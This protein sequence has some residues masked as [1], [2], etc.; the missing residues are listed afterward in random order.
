MVIV[1]SADIATEMLT[2]KASIYSDRPQLV[3]FGELVG[4]NRFLSFTPYGSLW[5][6]QRTLLQKTIGTAAS[7]KQFSGIEEAEAHRLLKHI[8]NDPENLVNHI[9]MSVTS[10]HNVLHSLMILRAAGSIILR[11]SYGYETADG[12][13]SLVDLAETVMDGFATTLRPGA[14]LVDL[15][16]IREELLHIPAL[17]LTLIKSSTYHIGF[18][19]SPS[20]ERLTNGDKIFRASWRYHT[21]WSRHLWYG[22]EHWVV[23]FTQIISGERTKPREIICL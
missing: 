15:L 14:F 16:P 1:N 18:R 23:S 6:R 4:F 3:M 5:R 2:R 13:D 9:R 19:V 8:R 11:I 7:S 17:S 12:K 22:F 21:H 20:N 10:F